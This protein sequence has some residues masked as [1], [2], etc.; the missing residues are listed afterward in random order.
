MRF[1]GKRHPKTSEIAWRESI[2]E[3][4]EIAWREMILEKAEIAWM[5]MILEVRNRLDETFFLYIYIINQLLIIR[6]KNEFILSYY[7]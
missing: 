7:Q 5:E 3:K 1:V 6:I 2:L 4:S